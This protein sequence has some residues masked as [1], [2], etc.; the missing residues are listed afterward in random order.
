MNKVMNKE[1]DSGDMAKKKTH[2][3]DSESIARIRAELDKL[4]FSFSTDK[5]KIKELQARA[6]RDPFYNPRLRQKPEV[7]K[8]KNKKSK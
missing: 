6:D 4:D 3:N 1:M 8:A 2:F 5:E 7:D